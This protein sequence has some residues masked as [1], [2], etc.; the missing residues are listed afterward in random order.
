MFTVEIRADE[1]ALTYCSGKTNSLGC[2][3]NVVFAGTPSLSSNLPFTITSTQQ[4][5]NKIGLLLYGLDQISSPFQGGLLCVRSPVRRTSPQGTGGSP[6]GNDCSG[7][8]DLD[9]NSRIQS[10]Q[11]PALSVE[12]QEVFVQFWSRDPGSASTT[13]LSNALRFVIGP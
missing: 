8:L 9:F 10:S 5:N 3:P 2:V 13:S 6:I 12:G 4:L 7:V 11:D 1:P